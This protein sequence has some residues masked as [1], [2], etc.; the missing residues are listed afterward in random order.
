MIR[1]LTTDLTMNLR[2]ATI[3]ASVSLALTSLSGCSSA[4][5]TSGTNSKPDAYVEQYSTGQYTQAYD[6]AVDAAGQLR[7]PKRD[8][9]A[10]TAGLSAHALGRNAE[11]VR[12]LSPLEQNP[13]VGIAGKAGATLGLI[14]QERGEHETAVKLLTRA[15]TKLA[16][17]EAARAS[18][19]AGDSLNALGRTDDA[20]KAYKQA[21]NKLATDDNLKLMLADR[22]RGNIPPAGKSGATF[23]SGGTTK[24]TSKSGSGSSIAPQSLTVQTGAYKDRKKAE[25]EARQI[26]N[27]KG[28]AARVVPILKNGQTLYAVRVGN[29]TNR[30]AAENIRRN[31]GGKAVV[32][33]AS[34]E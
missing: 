3:L 25:Q 29:F 13:D 4:A 31:V 33:V 17:D 22:M 26:A 34:G 8:Q 16:G 21:A 2:I 9:A 12:W 30:D 6:N 7:G 5:K 23:A 10:L 18:M 28:V 19:Y 24:S 1:F 11:A 32:T 27:T 14:A 15:S 20:K